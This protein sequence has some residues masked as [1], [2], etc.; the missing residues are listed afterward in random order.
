MQVLGQV[1]LEHLWQPDHSDAVVA[2]LAAA[3]QPCLFVCLAE[4]GQLSIG[5]SPPDSA[6]GS[7][8]FVLKNVENP[9]A[10]GACS[11][12]LQYLH[13]IL[14]GTD[15][16]GSLLQL[17]TGLYSPYLTDASEDWPET[18]HQEFL[19]QMHRFTGCLTA[20]VH[21]QRNR[22][23]LYVAPGDLVGGPS[24]ASRKREVVQRLESCILAWTELIGELLNRRSSDE[25]LLEE[26]P[27]AEIEFWSN[28]AADLCGVRAQLDDPE[29]SQVLKVLELAKSPYLAAFLSLGENIQEEAAKAESNVKFLS[30]LQA[31]CQKLASADLAA[32][33]QLLP[34]ILDL[35]RM[36]WTLSPYYSNSDRFSSL[37]RKVSNEV[38][39]RCRKHIN[40]SALFSG[41]QLEE[42]ETGLQ[43]SIDTLARWREIYH[44]AAAR[45]A[46]AAPGR[47]WGSVS[48]SSFA[49]VDAFVQRCR[50]LQEMC[51]AH[52]QFMSDPH[53]EA[54]LCGPKAAETSK[55]LSE[56]M[57]GNVVGSAYD[58]SATLRL[59]LVVLDA[60]Y[61]IA[62][63]EGLRKYV[64]TKMSEWHMQFM[65][66]LNQVKD[67]F[68]SI[69][70][71]LPPASPIAEQAG[72]ALLIVGLLKRI[73]TTWDSLQNVQAL[74]PAVSKAADSSA[75][76]E[77]LHAG[78]QQ[79]INTI[80]TQ[81]YRTVKAD[82]SSSLNDSLL[83][84]DK[85]SGLLALN[86]NADLA[87]LLDE[88]FLFQ[89]LRLSVPSTASELL[90]Q[91]HRLLAVRV[92]MEQLVDYFLREA[93]KFCRLTETAVTELK[94][95]GVTVAQACATMRSTLL[96][97]VERKRLYDVA[98]F[99]GKQAQHQE[100][101]R[102][103]LL[104]EHA[105]VKAALVSLYRC[106][107]KDSEEVQHEWLHFLQ[108]VDA[109]VLEALTA[110]VRRSL[111]EVVRALNGDKKGVEVP[112]V[113][114]M[115]VVLESNN[116]VEL[117]PALQVL[118]DTV[119]GVCKRA[120]CLLDGV[121][122]L[123]EDVVQGC[124]SAYGT[125]SASL[126]SVPPMPSYMELINKNEDAVLKQMQGVTAGITG[127]VEKVQQF[128]VYWEKKFRQTYEQDKD[129]YMRRYERACK[130]VSAFATD[131]QKFKDLSEEVLAE[132]AAASMRFLRLDCGPLK[133]VLAA[134]CEAW[135]SKFQ[136][137]LH[138]L[139]QRQLTNLHEIVLEQ[140]AGGPQ[141]AAMVTR[142]QVDLAQCKEK[143]ATLEKLQ[144]S[145]PDD[146]LEKIQTVERHLSE[147]TQA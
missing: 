141:A 142:L 42:A 69:K 121:P 43:L 65:H 72:Q 39:G 85:A 116:R 108:R 14:D 143:Y 57:L 103:K 36:L 87:A 9:T 47:A 146:E 44:A 106:L 94:V 61:R 16:P 41:Q 33:P 137:L 126:S 125:L 51:A 22:T 71:K 30:V 28:R 122:R 89:P 11:A 131:I 35:M 90:T 99:E 140:Q 5:N 10:D 46:T 2:Y 97:H 98:D 145:V 50:D 4:E 88:A 74:L 18:L 139:A 15:V 60:F 133:Q 49:H 78:M 113:F 1:A 95:T 120:V 37:L 32:V 128:L 101:A 96:T 12:P 111:T 7:V 8:L 107:S 135:I 66:E 100:A 84:Q 79:A 20:A 124:S 130:P 48:V 29:L 17:L 82:I 144:V 102:A 119:S 19:G 123:V 92:G 118:F 53:L 114:V 136:G 54:V 115:Q 3:E 93:I 58:T 6:A 55:A 75:A 129:A 64:E 91:R 26:G 52:R 76:Y 68:E 45:L 31:P 34:G 77:A 62:T 59:K 104:A 27:L 134:H 38:I 13:G 117:K 109:Q 21:A 110:C 25:L 86:M 105:R 132:E 83:R 63:R 24:A 80:N 23:V 138:T 56:L 73:D 81:W 147:P 70:L 67:L 127:I 40:L 112:P